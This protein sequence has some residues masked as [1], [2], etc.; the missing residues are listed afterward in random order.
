[1]AS[2]FGQNSGDAA[3]E[4]ATAVI[5]YAFET[6]RASALSAGHHPDNANSRKVLAKLGFL[7][8]HDEFFP[9]L[10]VDIPYYLL[11]RPA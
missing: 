4:A 1:M 9:A 11:R 7:Y 10:D 5:H 8:S 2:T 3:Q 6:L